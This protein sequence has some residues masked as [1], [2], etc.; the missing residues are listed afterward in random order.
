MTQREAFEAWWGQ[1]PVELQP[2]QP[3]T[4]EDTLSAWVWEA[5]Q[6]AQAAQPA[7]QV[8]TTNY[9]QPVPDHCDRI[10]WRN[11]YYHLPLAAELSAARAQEP[12]TDATKASCALGYEECSHRCGT[13]HVCCDHYVEPEPII[14]ALQAR[15]AELEKV[16]TTLKGDLTQRTADLMLITAELAAI[17]AREPLSYRDILRIYNEVGPEDGGNATDSHIPNA[18]T[19]AAMQEAEAMSKSKCC[20]SGGCGGCETEVDAPTTSYKVKIEQCHEFDVEATSLE[21]AISKAKQ[22]T[23]A[24]TPTQGMPSVCWMDTYITK[25]TVAREL[26]ITSYKE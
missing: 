25:E 4:R 15:V 5:W 21:E 9:V 7:R 17:K 12:L 18:E 24:M 22:F 1:A 10:T 3:R 19:I 2:L 11:R 23:R 26:V 16:V 20:G 14:E 8:P 6:A 13:P